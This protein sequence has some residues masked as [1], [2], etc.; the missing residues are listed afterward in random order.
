MARTVIKKG[1]WIELGCGWRA[2]RK[3]RASTE[4]EPVKTTTVSRALAALAVLGASVAPSLMATEARATPKM[5]AA[6]APQVATQLRRLL[7]VSAG[8][9]DAFAFDPTNPNLVYVGTGAT[10]NNSRVYKS[11]DAGRHWQPISPGWSWIGA[12]VSDPRHPGTLY[13][14]TDNGIHKTTNGGRTWHTFGQGLLP[15]SGVA[16]GE[17]FGNLAI[18]PDNSKILY[19]G[20]G[21]GVHQSADGG[22]TWQSVAGNRR[23]NLVLVAAT[24]PTTVYS[25][26][27]SPPPVTGRPPY[28]PVL[29]LGSSTNGGKTWRRTSLYAAEARNNPFATYAFAADP[30]SPTTIYAV[31]QTRVFMSTNAGRSWRPIGKGLPR[32]TNAKNELTSIAAAGNGTLYV[33]YQGNGIYRTTDTGQTWT[34]VWPQPGA[35]PG[36]G[37]SLL[38]IDPAR[39]TTIYA[40]TYYPNPNHATGAHLLRSTDSGTTWKTVG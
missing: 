16:R 5:S 14:S 11:S 30:G 10:N 6:A 15:P 8:P 12:L 3:A 27:F 25:V 20:L 40:S 2:R 28:N 17:G 23:R 13:A 33:A 38:G 19:S 7:P 31:F 1:T 34:R 37:A 32:Y 29:A 9:V 22:H 4:R 21:L 39:P 18:D 36:L 26:W 24:R 35:A